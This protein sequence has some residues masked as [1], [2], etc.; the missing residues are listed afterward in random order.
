MYMSATGNS[1]M[2]YPQINITDH[3]IDVYVCEFLYVC[4]VLRIMNGVL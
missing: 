3:L 2:M 1:D 4:V